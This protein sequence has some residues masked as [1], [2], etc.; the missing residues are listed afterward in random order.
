MIY[1]EIED[2][3]IKTMLILYEILINQRRLSKGEIKESIKLSRDVDIT[4]G[5]R[6]CIME[7]LLSEKYI[8][9]EEEIHFNGRMYTTSLKDLKKS[10]TD[11]GEILLK[12]LRMKN[13][14]W[15][16]IKE[17]IDAKAI[18]SKIGDILLSFIR[19]FV[20]CS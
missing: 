13:S 2:K 3:E 5:E 10:V 15:S 4:E 20:F 17:Y 16:K 11:D 19:K 6:N 1:Q 8:S 14:Q 12:R 7:Y 18:I 9:T